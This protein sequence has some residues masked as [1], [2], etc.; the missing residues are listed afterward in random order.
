MKG[1][2]I[3]G[4]CDVNTL[5]E[6]LIETYGSHMRMF[7]C[8]ETKVSRWKIAVTATD[9]DSNP[10]VLGNYNGAKRRRDDCGTSEH[11]SPAR[12]PGRIMPLRRYR[13][14]VP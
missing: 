11:P 1:L 4:L 5:E 8:P 3:D 7:D 2:L 13:M 14:P 10:F 9:M 12:G 6:A